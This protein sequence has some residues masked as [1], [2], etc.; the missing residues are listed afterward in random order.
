MATKS[1]T[2]QIKDAFIEEL[3]NEPSIDEQLRASL[4]EYIDA[5]KHKKEEILRLLKK[6]K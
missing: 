4:K 1:V 3:G 5:G 6:E 2:Q